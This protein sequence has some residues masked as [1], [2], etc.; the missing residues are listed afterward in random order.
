MEGDR[1]G[2]YQESLSCTVRS[3]GSFA[4]I[5]PHHKCPRPRIQSKR[6]TERWDR[7]RERVSKVGDLSQSNK[8]K[9][10]SSMTRGR[11][12]IILTGVQSKDGARYFEIRG[13]SKVPL[14][15]FAAPGR[16]RLQALGWG[17]PAGNALDGRGEFIHHDNFSS[18]FFLQ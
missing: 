13:T 8:G 1:R 7:K 11:T 12:E 15:L 5:Y 3:A 18:G 14:F 17:R 6:A 4:P 16:S 10:R 9:E 2:A